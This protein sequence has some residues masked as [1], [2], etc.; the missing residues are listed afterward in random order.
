MYTV[1]YKEIKKGLIKALKDIK[2]IAVLFSVNEDVEQVAE[3]FRVLI[4]PITKTTV[5]TS[6]ESASY[7]IDITY[8]KDNASESEYMELG[9]T[10][11]DSLRPN[12]KLDSFSILVPE[13]EIKVTDDILHYTFTFNISYAITRENKN[14]MMQELDIKNY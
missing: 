6:L 2:D 3:Y 11:D 9:E 1:M 5:S 8:V 13:A 14:E 12:I 4:R 10:I 7:L